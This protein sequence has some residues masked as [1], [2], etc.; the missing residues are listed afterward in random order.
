MEGQQVYVVGAGNSAGQAALHLARYAASVTSGGPRPDLGAR[1]SDYLVQE[2]DHAPN[3]TVR[4]N[5]QVVDG[6]GSWRLEGLVLRRG[7]TRHRGGSGG[8]PVRHDRRRAAHR[9]A[10]RGGARRPRLHPDRPRPARPGRPARRLAPPPAPAAAGDQRPRVFAAGDVRHRSVKRSRLGRRRG[11]PWPSSS[12][13][14]TWTASSE[15]RLPVKPR[16]PVA[17]AHRPAVGRVAVLAQCDLDRKV[18]RAGPG[19]T[20]ATRPSHPDGRGVYVMLASGRSARFRGGGRLRR[21]D[22]VQVPVA[23]GGEEQ[24]RHPGRPPRRSWPPPVGLPTLA[25]RWCAGLSY[26][27]TVALRDRG[28]RLP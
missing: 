2:I 5:S 20:T 23:V 10:G 3:V 1:M 19:G 8:R 6:L 27:G 21:G 15:M 22:P 9:L 25:A 11:A 26:P 12:S 4:L 16:S 24:R 17:H 14:S 7:D 13:T 18:T 28:R